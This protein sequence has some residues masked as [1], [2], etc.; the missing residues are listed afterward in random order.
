[1]FNFAG[2]SYRYNNRKVL[3]GVMMGDYASHR[4]LSAGPDPADP[5]RVL[6]RKLVQTSDSVWCYEE[7]TIAPS[8]SEGG[9]PTVHSTMH[10]LG[11][12]NIMEPLDDGELSFRLSYRALPNVIGFSL[13]SRAYESGRSSNFTVVENSVNK[14]SSYRWVEWLRDM[15]DRRDMASYLRMRWTL[16]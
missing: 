1:M 10:R 11:W 7:T 9:S 5:S 8:E 3:G 2:S 6:V 4:T 16:N 13:F 12:F 15:Q 14:Q